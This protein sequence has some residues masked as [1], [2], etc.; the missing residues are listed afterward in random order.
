[1]ILLLAFAYIAAQGM[2]YF[3]HLTTSD[4]LAHPNVMS[5]CQD[6]LG[7]IWFGTENG[8]SIYNGTRIISYKPY[9]VISGRICFKESL[10]RKLVCDAQ[11]RVFF[12]TSSELVCY[13]PESDSM[14]TLLEG[15]LTA[16]YIKDG[17]AYAVRGQ[18]HFCYNDDTRRMDSMPKLPFTGI[19]DMLVQNGDT[20][21]ICPE[22]L[23]V[24]RGN[25][26]Y[27]Q[28][29]RTGDLYS[30]F[31][32]S[33]GEIWTGSNTGGLLRV[34]PNGG[35]RHYTAETDKDRGFLCNNIRSIAE[36]SESRIWF[37]T[38]NGLYTYTP[39]SDTFRA[40]RRED[41]EGGLSSSSIHTVLK[42]RDGILWVGTY[43]GGGNY[44]DSRTGAYSFFPATPNN[45][46][47]LSA[48][49][50]G[51]LMEDGRGN[52]WICTE[53]GGLNR[54]EPGTGKISVY[55]ERYFT[56]AKW[57]A[58]NTDDN[59]LFIATNRHGLFRLDTR[60][61][62]ISQE[63]RPKESDS[64]FYVINI[65]DRYQDLLV[66]STN[67]GVWLHSC[68]AHKDTLLY[69]RTEGVRYVHQTISGNRLFLASSTVVEFDLD[70]KK[71]IR[72]YP[73]NTDN[74]RARPMRIL[75][76][77]DGTIYT[78]TFGHGIFRLE[79]GVFKPLRDTPRNGYQ[80]VDAGGGNLL[81]SAEQ[82]IL[83][84]DADGQVLQRY[85][86][87]ENLPLE[88]MV[89]D[90]GLLLTENGTIYAGGTN[91][92]VS[93]SR[94]TL[95]AARK[96]RLY[97]SNVYVNG[98][99]LQ[100]SVPVNGEVAFKG[101]Q[102]RLD[103]H[104]SSR[105]NITSLD[106]SRYEYRLYGRD[107]TWTAMEGPV[108]SIAELKEGRYQLEV[109]RKDESGTLCSLEL[110]ILPHWYATP[111]AKMIYTLIAFGLIGFM[112]R[113]IYIRQEAS[114]AQQLNETKLRF[115]TTV[116]H[117]LRSPLTI[118]I[119]QIDS[120]IQSYHLAPKVRSKMKKVRSQAQQ[121]NQLVNEIIDFRKFEQNMVTLHRCSIPA[122]LFVADIVEKFRELASSRGLE[123]SFLSSPDDP[124]VFIDSS[125]MQKVLMNLIFNAVK[126]TPGGGKIEL[127]VENV[128]AKELVR[129]HVMDTGIGIKEEDR[130]RIFE[131]FYQ[132]GGTGHVIEGFP[133]SGLGLALSKDIVQLHDGS[134]RAFNRPGGGSDFVITL[135]ADNSVPGINPTETAGTEPVK[136]SSI[137][138]AEDNTEM[139]N[140]LKE[141]FSVQYEVY[142]AGDGA[143]ALELVK[144]V[145]PDLVLSDLVMP[146]MGGDE[147]LASIK[148]DQRLASIP[149]VLLT[150]LDDNRNRLEGLLKGASD[151]IAKPF[152]PK[153]LLTRC[154]NLVR[155]K[156]GQ[157]EDN[158]GRRMSLIATNQEEKAF[159]DRVFEIIDKN[160]GNADLDMDTLASLMNMS[161]S[162]FY[163]RFKEITTESPAHY[164]N[165]RRLN[166]ACEL[167]C[168]KPGLSIAEIS[169]R[170]GFKTQNYFSRRFKQR[171]GASP[172]QYRK[173]IL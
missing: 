8:L 74:G 10:I 29:S 38:F 93:F 140:L 118:I 98:E 58:E 25:G 12:L 109:K 26:A 168:S 160:I 47:G 105:R 39:S 103:I 75:V 45:E 5:M 132:A 19:T 13:E 156:H 63:I 24:A 16:L 144:K 111:W 161:R 28:L 62:R 67:D 147:L 167:L 121:M 165:S 78:S 21:L 77:D 32:S 85:R 169:D 22:G 107:D 116:S 171:Y 94:N 141:I 79:N 17:S 152:D 9:D 2:P 125:Q 84:L 31:A 170:L 44:T 7:R 23:F 88:A 81:V 73:V 52:I 123:I 135:S 14:E 97:F 96:D 30:L 159:L 119:A 164:I 120:I 87:G 137:V 55:G 104:L 37:G 158:A 71:K 53:G 134:I 102:K 157:S 166:Q 95:D 129:I 51:H 108:V 131:R 150:A 143:E 3:K 40:Y 122:N 11:G 92:L 18:E 64:P 42:D 139:M 133:S 155:G 151:F 68:A 56:H 4:G 20:Y 115:F 54:L 99:A 149:V 50:A 106:W 36:D 41:R 173:K 162:R 80:L 117:E 153:I 127:E 128:P 46:G 65:V 100:S 33:A 148:G 172:L 124:N 89:L 15:D 61:G 86:V 91:G 83:L 145:V 136:G 59:S 43:Y 66:L 72:E 126:F 154:N 69:P 27:Q 110:S 101:L 130:E 76:M 114:R 49:V 48:P 1:M 90:S 57:V 35:I 34:F 142:P 113:S 138:I 60:S 112:L 6:S 146:R 70:R 82:Q 163:S